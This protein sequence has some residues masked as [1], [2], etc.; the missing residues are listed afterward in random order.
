MLSVFCG[1]CDV[2]CA[3]WSWFTEYR[4]LA[5]SPCCLRSVERNQV[6]RLRRLRAKQPQH[7][8]HLASMV[9]AVIDEVLQHRPERR[10]RRL[11]GQHLELEH[12][13]D[14]VLAERL[15]EGAHLRLVLGPGAAD[16]RQMRKGGTGQQCRRR[17]PLPA[18]VPRVIRGVEMRHRV[19]E[20]LEAAAEI[21]RHLLGAQLIDRFEHPVARPVVVAEQC[22]HIPQVHR[23]TTA[24]SS[25]S[26]RGNSRSRYAL[27][28][29]NSGCCLPA[30]MPLPAVSPYSLFSASAT[31]MPST[32][33]PNGT[34]P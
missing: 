15:D 10:R 28:P 8:R 24:R 33:R 13:A 5:P 6:E 18:R 9:A 11:P 19:V 26:S 27:P 34:K 1:F 12:A 4:P 23:I 22:S 14:A 7:H 16:R 31:S 29:S 20:R 25:R 32:T 30:R 17:F 3:R 2:R 21:A